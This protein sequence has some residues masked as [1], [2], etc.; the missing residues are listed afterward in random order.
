M[1]AAW[2]GSMQDDIVR[3][4]ARVFL[5]PDLL[6]VEEC[7][8]YIRGSGL[9]VLHSEKISQMVAATWDLCAERGWMAR[10]LLSILPRKFRDLF[11]GVELMREGFR[12]GKLNYSVLV[13]EK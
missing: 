6:T 12:S 2:T 9:R 7:A 8:E 5:C 11:D 4:I 10:P 1:L 3:E 13:A